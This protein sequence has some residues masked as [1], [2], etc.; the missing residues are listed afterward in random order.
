MRALPCASFALLV[1]AFLSSPALADIGEVVHCADQAD[2]EAR[3]ACYDAAVAKLKTEAA[4]A[5]TRGKTLFGLPIPFTEPRTE[6]NFGKPPAAPPEVKEVTEISGKLVG[7]TKDP[8][9]R[10]ILVL[11][12]GQVWKVMEYKPLLVSTSG[13][14]TVR[15][16][17]RF[18]GGYYMSVNGADTNLTVTRLK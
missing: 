15:I 11:D 16:E 17:R 2:D 9:G 4:D 13:T 10:P 8:L 1:A 14:T 7:W 5:Q 12:N 6:Q 3:L 18:M